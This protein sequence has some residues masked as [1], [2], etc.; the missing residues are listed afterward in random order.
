MKGGGNTGKRKERK[1]KIEGREE[2]IRG[3]GRKGKGR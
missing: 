1:G 2:G 3:R